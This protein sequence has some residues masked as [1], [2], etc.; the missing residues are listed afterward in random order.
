MANF[1]A[2]IDTST[3][4]ELGT[5]SDHDGRLVVAHTTKD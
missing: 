4:V 5:A 3:K 1:G 2:V